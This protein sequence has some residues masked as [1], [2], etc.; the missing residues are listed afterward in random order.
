MQAR[1]VV[2]SDNIGEHELAA[3]LVGIFCLAKPGRIGMNFYNA[4]SVVDSG[5]D[6]FSSSPVFATKQ[7]VPR[8]LAGRY[9]R[10]RITAQSLLKKSDPRMAKVPY[11]SEPLTEMWF[12]PAW[13]EALPPKRPPG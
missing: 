5:N 13:V 7:T 12:P 2:G 11:S 4:A 8:R 10:R 6:S 1:Q 9:N 3:T